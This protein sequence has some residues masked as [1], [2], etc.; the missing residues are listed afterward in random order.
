MRFVLCSLSGLLLISAFTFGCSGSGDTATGGSGGAGASGGSGGSGGSGASGGS[1]GSG[2]SGMCSV[3]ADS[4]DLSVPNAPDSP[5]QVLE[6]DGT[7]G[8]VA[9]A[10][11][12]TVTTPVETLW[13]YGVSPSV[14][15]G[16]FV[17]V[18]YAYTQGF[19]GPDGAAVR[20]TNLPDLAGAANPT[21]AGTRLWYFAASGGGDPGD[22]SP[23]EATYDQ[24]CMAGDF[25]NGSNSV[26]SLTLTFGGGT[27]T[28]DPVATAPFTVTEGPDA[29]DYTA[30]NVNIQFVGAPGGDAYNLTNF[31]I[32]RAETP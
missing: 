27:V 23:F 1:G 2:G 15:D 8:S 24:V 12:F 22:L 18:A 9:D 13:F 7:F 30:H 32:A 31:I 28:V 20:V 16:T 19:Y 29:G 10:L 21:E 6:A 5:N 25:E 4:V 26:Q 17:H 14:P 11:G 3:P